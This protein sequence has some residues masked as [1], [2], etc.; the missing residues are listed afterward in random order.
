MGQVVNLYMPKLWFFL[1]SIC[2]GNVW[3]F[4]YEVFIEPNEPFTLDLQA[5]CKKREIFSFIEPRTLCLLQI[6]C[7]GA[8]AGTIRAVPD[9]VL[10]V[11]GLAPVLFSLAFFDF[12]KVVISSIVI[13]EIQVLVSHNYS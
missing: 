9:T 13:I 12:M 8:S 4:V 6:S 5:F 10:K 11:P 7:V 3:C 2:I 1:S